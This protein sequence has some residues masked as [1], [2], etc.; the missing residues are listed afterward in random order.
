MEA[1]AGSSEAISYSIRDI[2]RIL[3]LEGLVK[4][5]YWEE[6]SEN[7]KLSAVH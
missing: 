2:I 3:Y 7:F 5:V 1:V 4:L 6:V